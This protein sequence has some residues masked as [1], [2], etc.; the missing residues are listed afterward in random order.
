MAATAVM[1]VTVDI[2]EAGGTTVV[3]DIMVVGDIAAAGDI[4]VVGVIVVGDTVAGVA[5]YMALAYMV[6]VM[7]A[8]CGYL[9]I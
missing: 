8:V 4:T 5:V 2:T 3:G 9:N 7:P 1:V 6:Q